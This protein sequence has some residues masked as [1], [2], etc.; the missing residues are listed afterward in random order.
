[1][2]CQLEMLRL[3]LRSRVRHF[4]YELADSLDETY[5]RI[6]KGI[7]KTNHSYVQRLLQCLTMAIR[8]LTVKEL[9]QILTFDLDAIEG[10]VPTLDAGLRSEEQEQEL[11]SAC[12]SLITIV[13]SDRSRVVQFSHFSVKEFLTSERL[14]TSHEDIVRYHIIP[15]AAHTVLARAS[16]GAIFSLSGRIIGSHA[17]SIPLARY[18]AEHW[19]SHAQFGSVSSHLIDPMKTLFDSDRLHFAA[20]L[21][22]YDVDRQLRCQWFRPMDTTPKPLYY[23]AL[24]GFYDLT[25]HL[26]KKH[27]EDINAFGGKRDYP[28]VAALHGGY[29]RVAELLL[30]H[31][32]KIEV[33]GVNEQTP[34]HRALGWPNNSAVTVLQ[35]LLKHGADVTA[36]RKDLWTPLHLVAAR[37]DFEVAQ[38]PLECRV[39]VS[40]WKAGNKTSLNPIPNPTLHLVQPFLDCAEVNSRGELR[41]TSLRGSLEVARALLDHGAYVNAEDNQGRTPL[42]RVF[43]AGG[44][45]DEDRFDVAQLL[46]ERGANV[47]ARDKCEETPLHLAPYALKLKLVRMLVD[48]GANVNAKNSHGQTPL[49]RVLKAED[50]ANEDRFGVAQLLVERGADV[51]AQDM[52]DETPLQLALRFREHKV[53]RILFEHGADINVKE[54]LGQTALHRALESFPDEDRFGFIQLLVEHGADVNTQDDLGET[55]LHLALQ[56]L[57]LKFVRLLVDRGANVNLKNMQ[58]RTPLHRLLGAEDYSD[59]DRFSLAQQLIEHGADVNARDVCGTTPLHLVPCFWDLKLARMLVD[60]GANVNAEDKQGQTPLHRVLEAQAFSGED[61][62]GI[63]QLLAERGADVNARHEN[64][65]TPL[66]L[67]SYSMEVRLV[68]ILVDHGANVDAEDSRGRTPL[69]RVL[70]AKDFSE[71]DQIGT[72]RL[73]IERSADVNTSNNDGETPLHLAT[74][75]VS[76]EVVWVLLKHGADPNVKNKEGKTPFRLAQES[77]KG[78]MKRSQLDPFIRRTRRAQGIALM[79]LLHGCESGQY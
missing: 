24:C 20:W 14:A 47:N 41:G 57:E 79:G 32:A 17:A 71:Q 53:V 54:N 45:S 39:D 75:L 78:D 19:V 15:E 49:H 65:D 59:D 9:T 70:E 16:L 13:D 5:E 34:L 10:E 11:L 6:L 7:H 27:P 73:L 40:P 58:G 62:F 28:L 23:S 44:Y 43:G 42:H 60:H 68:R 52:C 36:R 61:R 63:A 67:A 76:L 30:Q 26:L 18:A 72:A 31:G 46:V 74:R 50:Y 69:H 56:F 12:P 66:H 2:F 1:M 55:P 48:H 38:M 21:R 25:L 8:P 77:M 37:R 35:F 33:Q 22:I 51:N 3:C 64:H 29:F 4:L